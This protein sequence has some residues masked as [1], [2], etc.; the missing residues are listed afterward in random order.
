MQMKWG[1]WWGNIPKNS[2]G[3]SGAIIGRILWETTENIPRKYPLECPK[4]YLKGRLLELQKT[5]LEEIHGKSYMRITGA[6]L[7]EV[8]EKLPETILRLLWQ[9]GLFVGEK[10][11][12]K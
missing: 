11:L 12:V 6:I 4:K 7:G 8:P 2:G 1:N 5:F 9:N 10:F 3:V